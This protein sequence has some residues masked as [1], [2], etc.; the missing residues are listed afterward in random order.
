M[1]ARI[2]QDRIN[3]WADQKRR[4]EIEPSN[5]GIGDRLDELACKPKSDKVLTTDAGQFHMTSGTGEKRFKNWNPPK[6]ERPEEPIPRPPPQ[7]IQK[8]KRDRVYK[9]FHPYEFY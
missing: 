9:I 6:K 5:Q 3:K 1:E 2:K 8:I 7:S 4:T